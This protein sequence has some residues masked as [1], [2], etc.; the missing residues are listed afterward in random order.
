MWNYAKRF[1]SVL[2]HDWFPVLNTTGNNLN[3]VNDLF[4]HCCDLASFFPFD[5]CFMFDLLTVIIVL[6]VLIHHTIKFI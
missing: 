5:Y 3:C 1:V 2:L 4:E 6:V